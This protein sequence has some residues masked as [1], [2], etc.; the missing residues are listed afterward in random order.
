MREIGV[1]NLQPIVGKR[2]RRQS[3]AFSLSK[4]LE[5]EQFPNRTIEVAV[6]LNLIFEIRQVEESRK[7][8]FWLARVLV[9]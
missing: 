9:I 4:P 1:Q 6:T 3:A 7:R 2:L 8:I 5:Q